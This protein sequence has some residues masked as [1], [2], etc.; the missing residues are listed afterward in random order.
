MLGGYRVYD[1]DAH[2]ILAPAMWETCRRNMFRDVP[3]RPLSVTPATWRPIRVIGL[4]KD[5]WSRI[6]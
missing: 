6:F 4:S 2:V 3:V 1:A 5:A